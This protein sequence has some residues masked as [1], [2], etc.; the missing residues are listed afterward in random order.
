[1]QQSLVQHRDV[2]VSEAN[3]ATEWFTALGM[4]AL[5]AVANS[6]FATPI[7]AALGLDSLIVG[8]ATQAA[9]HIERQ[10]QD[11]GA[12]TFNYVRAV[13]SNYAQATTS[14]TSGA[15]QLAA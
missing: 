9:A 7:V 5:N 3:P 1:M 13:T 10:N 14:S 15:L 12:L 4:P 6:V 11:F 8:P 2:R